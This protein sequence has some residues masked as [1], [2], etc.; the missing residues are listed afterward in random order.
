MLDEPLLQEPSSPAPL[1]ETP[2]SA[3]P[4]VAAAAAAET[5][6]G[7][8][9]KPAKAAPSKTKGKPAKGKP[10]K[11]KPAGTK[12]AREKSGSGLGKKLLFLILLII[13]LLAVAVF[14]LPKVG[15]QVPYI[16]KIPFVGEMLGGSG[17]GTPAS[18]DDIPAL[19]NRG[20]DQPVA[21]SG[22]V[23]GVSV[24]I[25]P[26]DKNGV[27]NLFMNPEDVNSGLLDNISTDPRIVLTIVEGQIYN[28]YDTPRTAIKVVGRL[29]DNNYEMVQ[30]KIVYAGNLLTEEELITLSTEEL[31]TRLQAR[32]GQL[33]VPPKSTI[34]FMVVFNNVDSYNYE[35]IIVSSESVPPANQIQ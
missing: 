16:D 1:A 15:V 10:A 28:N 17:G 2:V 35:C 22:P 13:I 29:F 20:G 14:V 27:L 7:R 8:A 11:G 30:E 33:T 5:T 3:A 31:E 24:S 21:D 19:P 9:P 32:T 18:V 34:P 4:A 12:S 26:E 23:G 6:K 25:A